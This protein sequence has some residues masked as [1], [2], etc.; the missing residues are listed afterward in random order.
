MLLYF[1]IIFEECWQ[2]PIASERLSIWVH[3]DYLQIWLEMFSVPSKV[4]G[5]MLTFLKAL[6]STQTNSHLSPALSS[7]LPQMT[8][9]PWF[10]WFKEVLAARQCP[11]PPLHYSWHPSSHYSPFCYYTETGW[12]PQ[13]R[14]KYEHFWKVFWK[15][16]WTSYKPVLK[17]GIDGTP[18]QRLNAAQD[19]AHK[20]NRFFYNEAFFNI[21]FYVMP[22]RRGVCY[23]LDWSGF[24]VV[25]WQCVCT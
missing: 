12:P 9:W 7:S 25:V 10:L 22:E 3:V 15:R 8:Q 6:M 11:S 20:T 4:L 2:A 17:T 13:K 16:F 21:M 24:F 14:R 23:T 18:E 1:N 5:H 19:A